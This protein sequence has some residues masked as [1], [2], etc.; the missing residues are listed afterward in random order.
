[1]SSNTERDAS[2]LASGNLLP[3]LRAAVSGAAHGTHAIP[4]A[5]IGH[6]LAKGLGPI[7]AHVLG[8]AAGND[9]ARFADRI[10][11]ADLTA[12]LLTAEKYELLE[13]VLAA[14]ASVGCRPVL[15]KGIS[16]A[17]RYYPAPHLRTMGDI[18]L[19]VATDQQPPVEAQLRGLGFRQQAHQPASAF[20]HRHHS[21]PFW[22][23]DRHIWIE[24]H[25][26]LHPVQSPLATHPLF[27]SDA[28]TPF[29]THVTIGRQRAH[30]MNHELQLVYTSTRWLDRFDAARGVYPLLDAAFIL[31]LH[32]DAL[33][34]DR[35]CAMVKESWATTAL[36]LLLAYIRRVELAPVPSDILAWLAARDRYS[37][38]FSSA[39]LHTL[40][41]TYVMQ[42]RPFGLLLSNYH[43]QIVWST[44]IR[45]CRP[46]ANL[47]SIPYFVVHPPRRAHAA[48][49]SPLQRLRS[50]TRR[51]LLSSA[52]LNPRG[53]IPLDD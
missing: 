2:Q 32:G 23:P 51:A 33:D 34:W 37:N 20:V 4:S 17:V 36:H 6:A 28:I 11:A 39:L 5:A 16:T 1:M 43:W 42:G 13:T 41:N 45:P 46:A 44:L 38:R 40:V 29:L 12:R 3:L 8:A 27:A 47:L 19:L 21:M 50:L 35:V 31:R 22:H 53:T 18:D 10:R 14:L 49:R 15:L 26:G 30:A 7:V 25:T 9:H 48:N 52:S 24:V